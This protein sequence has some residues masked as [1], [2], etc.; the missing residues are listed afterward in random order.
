MVVAMHNHSRTE[1]PNE[2]A[3]PES[4]EAAM[5]ISKCLQGQPRHRALHRGQLRRCR[6][7]EGTSRRASRTST[8]R[9]ARRTR[10]TTWAWGSG[11]TPIGDVLQLL[12]REKWPIRAYIESRAW[13]NRRSGGR[14]EDLLCVRQTGI[15][16]TRGQD[17]HGPR[18]P[19]VRRRPSHR[20]G[21]TARVRRCHRR[22][23]QHRGVG[24][25]Q[26]RCPRRTESLRQLRSPSARSGRPRRPQYDAQLPPRAGHHGRARPIA[27][28]S[29]RTSRWR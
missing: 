20:C 21:A 10:A 17:W 1:D 12:K 25:P 3:R 24:A 8:S 26:G 16:M 4:F 11:D 6:L 19:G 7:P 13:R 2:F 27:N 5:K 18:G 14:S 29:S 22:R 23:R 28:T 9:T 15:R